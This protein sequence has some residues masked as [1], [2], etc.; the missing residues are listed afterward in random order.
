MYY[1]LIVP[2]RNKNLISAKDIAK[3]FHISY[4]QVNYYT[5][6]GFFIIYHNEGNQRLYDCRQIDKTLKEIQRL[7]RKGYSLRLIRD[8]LLRKQ[9][10]FKG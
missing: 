8:A 9:N 7:R 2:K 10:V 6:L 4:Q 1:T 5:N 3:K